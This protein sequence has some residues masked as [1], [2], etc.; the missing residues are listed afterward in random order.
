MKIYIAHPITGLSY[1][2]VVTYYEEIGEKLSKMG[3]KVYHPMTGKSYLRTEKELKPSG[4]VYPVSTDHAIK[5]RDKWMVKQADVVFVDF[6]GSKS[7]SIGCI[8]E[9]AWADDTPTVHTVVV[10]PKNNVHSHAFVKE[11]ADVV[12]ECKEEVFDYLQKLIDMKV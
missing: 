9:L 2:E 10:L 11:M 12:F 1:D 7:V 4:Y 5:E 8:C 3:Y 6:T